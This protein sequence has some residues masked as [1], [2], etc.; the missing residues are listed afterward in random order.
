VSDLLD[1]AVAEAVGSFSPR[2]GFASELLVALR[3]T[4]SV[5][6]V[7]DKSVRRRPR[8][9]IPGSFAGAV[10]AAGVLFY[11]LGRRHR[12]N[13]KKKRSGRSRR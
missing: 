6:A 1:I 2:P 5:P 12:D 4:S 9:L 11:G 10:G 7:F 8:W 13:K 3:G